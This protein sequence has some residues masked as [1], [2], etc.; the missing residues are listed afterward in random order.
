MPL[1][2]YGLRAVVERHLGAVEQPPYPADA[3]ASSPQ[4]RAWRAAKDHNDRI[5]HTA[6]AAYRYI[7]AW[8]ILGREPEM[9]QVPGLW[10]L[11]QLADGDPEQGWQRLRQATRAA[12]AEMPRD[13]YLEP[14]AMTPIDDFDGGENGSASV[15]AQPQP[16]QP[17]SPPEQPR[18]LRGLLRRLLGE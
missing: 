15:A 18:A 17:P 1:D 9:K 13:G 12:L 10:G 3:R 11:E 16:E 7:A 4:F 2:A 6:I 8:E 5:H 14:V